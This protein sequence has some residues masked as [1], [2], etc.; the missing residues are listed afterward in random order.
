MPITET[1][2]N[3]IVYGMTFDE[4]RAA[5]GVNQSLLKAG[6]GDK[7]LAHMRHE[8]EHP[9]PPTAA[10][11][12][13]SATHCAALEPDRFS[14][15][16][17]VAPDGA[18]SRTTGNATGAIVETSES[19]LARF[20]SDP[21]INKRSDAGKKE[22]ADFQVSAAAKGKNILAPAM[23]D[24]WHE[25]SRANAGK[26]ILTPKEFESALIMGESVLRAAHE[27][28]DDIFSGGH[29]EV[30][31]FWTDPF[32]GV[33]CKARLDYLIVRPGYAIISDVKSAESLA[34]RDFQNSMGK[35]NY[36]FQ[37]TYYCRGIQVIFDLTDTRFLFA[38]V[39]NKKP[40]L[41]SIFSLDAE[42]ILDENSRVEQMLGLYAGAMES[43]EWPGYV[44]RQPISPPEWA[45]GDSDEEDE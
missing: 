37:A 2:Q 31:L 41:S 12:L 33:R 9:S 8:M 14:K 42:A 43:G 27:D 36:T 6:L 19:F 25:F 20:V 28:E 45:L 3:E 23:F 24:K 29:S 7:T 11:R 18:G 16:Y 44:G 39:E 35:F 21:K 17:T 40:H 22:W 5:P 38:G 32:C 10:M 34:Y 26:T 30:S 15:S 1:P 13:G 4:Y